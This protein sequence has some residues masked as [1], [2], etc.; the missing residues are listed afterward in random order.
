METII[1]ERIGNGTFTLQGE[2][3]NHLTFKIS[4]GRRGYWKDQRILSIMIGSDNES[5]YQGFG[6]LETSGIKMW[7]KVICKRNPVNGDFLTRDQIRACMELIISHGNIGGVNGEEVSK[8]FT[9]PNGK[10]YIILVSTRC[11][12]CNR[13]L[14]NPESVKSGIGPECSTKN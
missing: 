7:S 10:E 13:K 1:Q 14:T 6:V 2:E 11:I 4:T 3:G 8:K 5:D 12:R 9:G